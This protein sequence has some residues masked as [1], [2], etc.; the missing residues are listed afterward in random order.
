MKGGDGAFQQLN[1]SA[2]QQAKLKTLRDDFK[3]KRD[4]LAAQQLT[5]AER[6]TQVQALHQQQRTQLETI[7][8]PEQKQQLAKFRSEHQGQKGNRQHWNSDNEAHR[9][10][11]MQELNLSTEQQ[12]K[13]KEMRNGFKT[14]ADALRND[15]SLTQEQRRT[16]LH[17]LMQQ[18]QAQL[19]TT[20]TKEQQE[21]LKALR[22]ERGAHNT[23]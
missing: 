21:K 20:L 19:K 16:K 12:A 8:T 4:A 13:V 1:L 22:Q 3:Q 10:A 18:Q 7:L 15:Q 2:E 23:R 11:L 5:E 9:G 6:R 17:E 14:K